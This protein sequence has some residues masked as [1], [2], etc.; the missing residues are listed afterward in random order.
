MRLHEY[1]LA[2]LFDLVWHNIQCCMETK[3]CYPML[4]VYIAIVDIIV[5]DR[6]WSPVVI[7]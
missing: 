7:A 3:W 5:I 2:A 1:E 4:I 6:L